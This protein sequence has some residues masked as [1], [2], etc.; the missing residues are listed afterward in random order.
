[1]R[2]QTSI[3]ADGSPVEQRR[4]ASLVVADAVADPIGDHLADTRT[5]VRYAAAGGGVSVAVAVVLIVLGQLVPG[6]AVGVLGAAGAAAYAWWQLQ[7]EPDVSV[8]SAQK[9]YWTGHVVP[10]SDG[11]LIYDATGTVATTELEVEQFGDVADIEENAETFGEDYGFPVV[12]DAAHD[13]EASVKGQLETTR[14][15]V[16]SAETVTFEA[17]I[18]DTTGSFLEELQSLPTEGMGGDVPT[19]TIEFDLSTARDQADRIRETETMAFETDP[20][21]TFETLKDD[22]GQVVDDLT[23]TTAETIQRLNEH[24]D[25]VG[26]ITSMLSYDFY[27]P[28]CIDD[29]VYAELNVEFDGD[30]PVWYCET[31][32]TRFE[33][34]DEPVPKHR[35]KDELVEEIW[36]RLWIE[37]DDERRRIYE[38]IEDQKTELEERE[39]EQ[40][41]E[42]IR[43]AWSRI[44]DLRSKIRDLETEAKAE[45][46]AIAEIG[47]VMTKYDRLAAE[48]REA[49][50]S[51][52][53]EALTE[54]EAAT[55]EAIEEMR[56]YEEEKL[57]E[58]QEEAKERAEL[59]RAEERK[60]HQEK[61]AKLADIEETQEDLLEHQKE[62]HQDEMLLETKGGTSASGLVNKYHMKKGKMFGYSKEEE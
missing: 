26:D 2:L 12:Q 49:F 14:N 54:I 5:Q 58:S 47:D 17:P 44:K 37:K 16:E 18:A 28:D 29:D 24:V 43:T 61:M 23:G 42:A 19:D 53:E 55:E 8:V 22:S 51:D 13:V 39:F 62:A 33:A 31:C 21:E 25:A 4:E 56:N 45:R 11:A 50:E 34:D 36:D 7:S 1:M 30:D 32:R 27:C 46:G 6:I 10:Q 38:N 57:E 9:R 59:M 40:R 35:M 52:V 20:E 41:Q 48:R 15:R 3:F 60:R